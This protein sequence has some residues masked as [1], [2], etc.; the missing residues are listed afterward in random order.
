MNG[1]NDLNCLSTIV[2]LERYPGGRK[3]I[4]VLKIF[5]RIVKNNNDMI[6]VW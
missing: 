2:F 6:P 5:Y 1:I 3:I 4:L